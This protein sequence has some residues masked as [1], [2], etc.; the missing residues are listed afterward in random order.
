[1]MKKIN[2]I[3]FLSALLCAMMLFSSC[4][5][6]EPVQGENPPVQDDPANVEA[7]L[8]PQSITDNISD[9]VTDIDKYLSYGGDKNSA[10]IKN[11]FELF[12]SKNGETLY[13]SYKYVAVIKEE[14]RN[15]DID[16]ATPDI[17]SVRYKAVNLVNGK[18]IYSSNLISYLDN[19]SRPMTTYSFNVIS[20]IIL[21]VETRE[22]FGD[23]APQRVTFDYYTLDGVK[24]L[25]VDEKHHSV[26]QIDYEDA[27]YKSV[28]IDTVT[29][30]IRDDA[31]VYKFDAGAERPLP[32]VFH[33]Y[34]DYKYV[35]KNEE[36]EVFVQILDLN[37][38]CL[39][40]FQLPA[41]IHRNIS[42]T[43]VTTTDNAIFVLGNGNL[44]IRGVYE[45]SDGEDYDFVYLT[46][47]YASYAALYD[48]TSGNAHEINLD[49]F[50]SDLYSV[51]YEK[52]DQAVCSV[53]AE[54][55]IATIFKY[56]ATRETLTESAVVL[57]NEL[58]IVCELPTI[59]AT[60]STNA[61]DIIY[62][63]QTRFIFTTNVSDKSFVYLVDSVANTVTLISNEAVFMDQYFYTDKAI[64]DYSL[65]ELYRMGA[66]E[67]V[68][69]E[70]GN[71][72]L[73]S[74]SNN[75]YKIFCMSEFSGS[76]VKEITSTNGLRFVSYGE[77]YVVFKNE[78]SI[79]D[80]RYYIYNSKGECVLTTESAPMISEIT[81]GIY[82]VTFNYYESV[83]VG[84]YS[85]TYIPHSKSI[86]LSNK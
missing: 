24:L 5:E 1:M 42:F 55:N 75:D 17:I 9:A 82:L 19:G 28:T 34:G 52:Y 69:A 70:I 58:N 80:S 12:D 2:F 32:A 48:V 45:V 40:Q 27:G 73:I 4:G 13:S 41:K 49:F 8:P 60:Q 51:Q 85:Y 78:M 56:D 83:M 7:N 35:I 62:V 3:V 77:D 11:A 38:I 79:P 37:Y 57:D 66:G 16:P 74:E 53:S 20:N 84:E 39:S 43:P 22:S 86:V 47:K 30:I 59:L 31:I 76:G 29:Y 21:E 81:D 23:S 6:E 15:T 18:A 72:L 67:T 44:L 65:K 14:R 10:E 26:S 36:G 63:D 50:V 46:K 68:Y 54:N 71:G 61:K 64:Y 33:E 25:S